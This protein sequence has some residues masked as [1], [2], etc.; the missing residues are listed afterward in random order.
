MKRVFDD[1]MIVVEAEIVAKADHPKTPKCLGW[2]DGKVT[3]RNQNDDVVLSLVHLY[4]V[5]KL[6][7]AAGESA[8]PPPAEEQR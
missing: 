1:D 8:G 5:E 4:I 3:V 7:A 6:V 2:V